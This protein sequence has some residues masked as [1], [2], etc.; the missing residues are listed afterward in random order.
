MITAEE[1]KQHFAANLQNA[2]AKRGVSQG[3]VARA[4]QREG[5]D[6]QVTR[7]RISRLVNGLSVPDAVDLSNIAEALGVSVDELLKPV[8]KIAK[9]A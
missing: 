9:S 2:I 1:A 4:T 5:E 8:K 3:D 7:N 6:L